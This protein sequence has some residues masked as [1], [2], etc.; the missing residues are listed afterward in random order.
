MELLLKPI[1]VVGHR[2]QNLV[3]DVIDRAQEVGFEDVEL[4]S[5]NPMI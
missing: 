4:G 3:S 2:V 1:P 5:Q